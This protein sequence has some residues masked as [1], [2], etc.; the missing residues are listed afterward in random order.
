[1]TAAPFP[2]SSLHEIV[3]KMTGIPVLVIGDVMLDRF[4]IGEVSRISPES[5]IPILE[6]RRETKM[7]GGAG[8]V[9]RNLHGLAATAEIVALIGDDAEGKIVSG[10][11][12]AAGASAANLI[13][14]PDHPT[15]IKTRFVA[16]RQ[17]LLRVDQ[18]QKIR[19]T[20]EQES[21][22]LDRIRRALP[23]QKAVVLSDY[24][25][26]VLTQA[27][28]TETL[29]LALEN[30][31]P[32]LVDP[33]GADYAK[34]RGASVV[35]PNRKEL[36][37]TAGGLPAQEDAEIVAAARKIAEECGIGAVIATRSEDGMTI[38]TSRKTE[39]PIHLRTRAIE[40]FDVSGAGD[41]VIATVAAALATG[42]SL[43]VAAGLANVAA[44]IV[45]AKIGTAAIRQA[46]L[47]EMLDK[48]DTALQTTPT[49]AKEAVDL[50]RKALVCTWDEAQEQIERWRAR[51]LKVGFTNGCFDILHAGHVNYLNDARNFCDRLVLG[52]NY[53]R[54]VQL[55]KGPSRPINDELSRATVIGGLGC[56]DMVVFFGAQEKGEDNTASRLIQHIQPDLYFKGADYTIE[57][58]PEAKIVQSYGGMVRLIPLT[59]GKST[60]A[61]LAKISAGS[62]EAA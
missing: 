44:G 35:T 47:L 26:G 20:G 58:I 38:V 42:A 9:L 43:P 60:T 8:N 22:V 32:V 4:V 34:Y 28:L 30:G 55:L 23:Q 51:G 14:I 57:R 10:L 18:E 52:L 24:G 59:E 3:T 39:D 21:A 56:V 37:E 27:V 61:T 13:T 12:E 7:L 46:E 11:V 25:K 41:T 54:S 33:K 31:I 5:P 48:G 2:S 19:L 45:V 40:V 16:S 50:S 36:S 17:Q 53:D 1:M 6:V 49:S 62:G 15:T 29:R